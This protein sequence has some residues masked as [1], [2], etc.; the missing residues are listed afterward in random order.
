M[1]QRQANRHDLSDTFWLSVLGVVICL[2]AAALLLV[3]RVFPKDFP[4]FGCI[5]LLTGCLHGVI[6]A[7]SLLVLPSC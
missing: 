2:S 5:L 6:I 3:S 4:P 1:S 7:L